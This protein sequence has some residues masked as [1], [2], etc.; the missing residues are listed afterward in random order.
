MRELGLRKQAGWRTL[1]RSACVHLPTRA[2]QENCNFLCTEYSTFGMA[3]QKKSYFSDVLS[4]ESERATARGGPSGQ[5]DGRMAAREGHERKA[6]STHWAK[7]LL[8]RYKPALRS[9]IFV[10]WTFVSPAMPA[11]KKKSL[12]TA[13]AREDTNGRR[14]AS[15]GALSHPSPLR[16]SPPDYV[17]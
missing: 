15:F 2:P 4:T 9:F 3:Y 10:P 14:R 11:S 16:A 1:W 17:A 8:C 6:D 12:S 7:P 5:D 13:A